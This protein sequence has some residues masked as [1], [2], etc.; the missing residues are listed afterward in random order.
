LKA[1][2]GAIADGLDSTT[3]KTLRPY[4]EAKNSVGDNLF[5]I[6]NHGLDH[7][8]PEFQGTDYTYQKTHFDLADE[9]IKRIIG[10]QMHTFGTPF[11]GSDTNTNKVVAQNENYKVFLF[12]RVVPKIKSGILYLDH[13]TNMED[14]TGNPEF[15]FLR[16]NYLKNKAEY[17]D[18]M[19]LQGH[20]NMWSPEKIDQFKK[21]IDFLISEGCEFVLPFYYYQSYEAQRK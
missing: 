10:V 9:K 1:A 16:D 7:I 21:I 11:N 14:G 5:E 4:L 13:R 17:K 6:W 12:S 8:R 19:V 20:P 15:S 2:L 18:Y 3:L